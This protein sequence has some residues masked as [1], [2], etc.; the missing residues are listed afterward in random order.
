MSKLLAF[1]FLP[2]S[3]LYGLGVSI[4][5]VLYFSGILKAVRF[6]FPV[7]CIGNLT[8]GG[9]GKSPHVEYFIRL[10]KDFLELG[11]LS[12]GY[13]RK[14]SGFLW[15]DKSHDALQ[16]GDE[17]QQI[18][19]KFRDVPVAVSESRALGIPRMIREMPDLQLILLDDA[20]QHLEVKSSL[21]ILLTEYARPY[22]RDF[23]LPSGRLREWRYGSSR[24][25]VVIVTKC[26]ENLTEDD[27]ISFRKELRLHP[28]QALFFSKIEYGVPYD[29]FNPEKIFKLNPGL[30]ITLISA[31][32]QSSYLEDYLNDRVANVNSINFEDH[33]YFTEMELRGLVEKYQKVS[34][35]N[36]MILTTEKDATRL[37]LFQTFFQ[38][39]QF[40]VYAIPIEVKFYN[41]ESFDLYIRNFLLEYKV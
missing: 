15:V 25:H 21:N 16:V 22:S 8:V 41:Q 10:L 5:Q 17:P 19:N 7:I 34:H 20:F 40:D 28:Q 18:K 13:K 26:P 38:K 6:S 12:R 24:A 33:H 32:A 39:N 1:L 36:K 14:T 31:I 29:I 37:K 9:T 2:F 35:S 11:V 4:Y 3:F 30:D 27:F 23:L